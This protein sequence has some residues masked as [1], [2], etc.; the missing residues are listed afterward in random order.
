MKSEM[1]SD[2][3]MLEPVIGRKRQGNEER[4]QRES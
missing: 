3:I 1:D 4:D 2:K